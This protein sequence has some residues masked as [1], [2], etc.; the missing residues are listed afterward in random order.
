MGKSIND[1]AFPRSKIYLKAMLVDPV[2]KEKFLA[3][4][5]H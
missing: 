1:S 5:T 2:R 3:F 4:P